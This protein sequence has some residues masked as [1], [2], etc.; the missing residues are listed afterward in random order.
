MLN[1]LFIF[2]QPIINIVDHC[3]MYSK[4]SL[5]KKFQPIT[6]ASVKEQVGL[7]IYTCIFWKAP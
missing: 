5:N 3:L 7:H 6:T 2:S 1:K 4:Q